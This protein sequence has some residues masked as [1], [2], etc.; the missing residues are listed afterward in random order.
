MSQLRT[1]LCAVDF[2]E[3]SEHA[4]RHAVALAAA[5]G[6]ELHVAHV[7]AV[8]VYALPD[9]ALV[10]GPQW[11]ARIMSEAEQ[12]M[13]ALLKRVDTQGV[14]V[15]SHVVEG[16]PH[17]EIPALAARLDADLVIVGTHG[18]TG[19][20]HLLLGSVAERIVRTAER[21]VMT[22]RPPATS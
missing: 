11:A 1:L 3:P 17:E 19:L 22:V 13:Q 21:P 14:K 6:A 8:P 2:S 10:A 16:A 15:S 9:G 5:L 7:Y 20:T 4:L 18:R 12:Q